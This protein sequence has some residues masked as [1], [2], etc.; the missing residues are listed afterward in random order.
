LEKALTGISD[1]PL[2]HL[3]AACIY[4]YQA[5]REATNQE[6]YQAEA[7]KNLR[8]AIAAGASKLAVFAEEPYLGELLRQLTPG[9]MERMES[10]KQVPIFTPL[11]YEPSTSLRL[12]AQTSSSRLPRKG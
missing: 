8:N 7:L 4:L 3:D 10:A 11:Y 5:H 2:I 6:R 1:D 9:E 12:P